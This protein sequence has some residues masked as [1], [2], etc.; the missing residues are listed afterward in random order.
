MK[1]IFI[2]SGEVSGDETAAWYL[3]KLY[4][5]E[6]NLYVE[7]VGGKKL[8]KLDVK[9]YENIEKLN[10]SG[11]FEIFRRLKFILNFL[12][13]LTIYISQNNFDEVIL[14]DFPGFNLRLAKKLKK[15]NSKIKIVYLSPPQLW[16]WG[17]WRI[18]KLKKFCDNLIV[19]YP[20]E[21]DWYKKHGVNADFYGNPIFSKIE[22]F[23]QKNNDLGHK[24]NQIAILPASR[25]S[26]FEKL[27]PIFADIIRRFKLRWPDVK[28]ILPLADS[29]SVAFVEKYLRKFGLLKLGKDISIVQGE[30]E[31]L[32]ALNQ[33]CL[34][35][36]KPG[37]VSLELALLKIPAV[38]IYKTSW[39]TYL[40][41]RP[42]VRI[43][44]MALPNL[45]LN[46]PIYKEF[47]QKNCKVDLI[48]KDAS[49]LYKKILS[50]DI[51]YKNLDNNFIK[52]KDKFCSDF[53]SELIYKV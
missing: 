40:I 15:I 12:K 5:K 30:Q 43:K 21:I 26:E 10:V 33:C 32:K 16:A 1:K 46:N 48:F 52:I 8:N 42:F 45:F 25:K 19:I 27:F 14:V 28:F 6:K 37:T 44:Y 34:A 31:K 22:S 49:G 23:F 36:S 47:I 35:I 4:E 9:I 2:V 18:K 51:N 20:F 3:K 17:Q 24:K 41:A 29:F 53:L 7:A 13:K 39:F 11:I 38:I 50:K